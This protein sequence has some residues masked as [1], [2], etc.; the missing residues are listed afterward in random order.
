MFQLYS[1][2]DASFN[3]MTCVKCSMCAIGASE[4]SK[5]QR[6]TCRDC[7]KS[8]GAQAACNFCGG[9]LSKGEVHFIVRSIL[10]RAIFRCPYNCGEVTLT[11]DRI[12]THI[13]DEC[14]E[15]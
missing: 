4:C 1:G 10:E 12:E 7:V 14:A 3:A 15:A 5:C 8:A 13:Q 9:A 2:S 11:F 6:L